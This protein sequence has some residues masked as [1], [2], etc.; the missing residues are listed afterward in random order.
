MVSK[1]KHDL[2]SILTLGSAL[3][4]KEALAIQNLLLRNDACD[5]TAPERL[6]A[7]VTQAV[8]LSRAG[9]IEEATTI[10]TMVMQIKKDVFG[11]THFVSLG[12]MADLAGSL[13]LHGKEALGFPADMQRDLLKTT[14]DVF[15]SDPG[16]QDKVINLLWY[17]SHAGS[18][19]EAIEK[20][21]QLIEDFQ[22]LSLENGDLHLKL[23]SHLAFILAHVGSTFQ[24]EN[25]LL[26]ALRLG[27]EISTATHATMALKPIQFVMALQLSGV[28]H[29]KKT[30][31]LCHSRGFEPKDYEGFEESINVHRSA[32]EAAIIHLS[33]THPVAIGARTRLAIV[34]SDV[35]IALNK[36]EYLSAASH[37]FKST[38]Q[39]DE[40]KNEVHAYYPDALNFTCGKKKTQLSI[41]Q[42]S[43]EKMRQCILVDVEGH[44]GD[45]AL[46]EHFI[47]LLLQVPGQYDFER[48]RLKNS[49]EK[50]CALRR[51]WS[52]KPDFH[53]DILR[54]TK[55]YGDLECRRGR[56]YEG[57]AL[58]RQLNWW[59]PQIFREEHQKQI[60]MRYRMD[61]AL[62]LCTQKEY[63]P[64]SLNI[65][66]EVLNA[67]L[68]DF[69]KKHTQSATF[70]C[71]YALLLWMNGKKAD[72]TRNYQ[73][74]LEIFVAL[75][76]PRHPKAVD[77][78]WNLTK[79]LLDVAHR[80]EAKK[81]VI[82]GV[83]LFWI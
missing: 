72:S 71:N 9:R 4:V 59:A 20:M 10:L 24:D 70:T 13:C 47:N 80:S 79:R 7:L 41:I 34:L 69:G 51:K 67:T 30:Q 31:Y 18:L 38:M 5:E 21:R 22:S 43:Y 35:G 73:E 46:Q 83:F 57:I 63:L 61:L 53:P 42:S 66:K 48:E 81:A 1:S 77:A 44:P 39:S 28:I 65:S 6:S 52:T 40:T 62:V 60:I 15:P 25:Y 27:T 33:P 55:L 19:C 78:G 75:L 37:L 11:D 26:E 64:K 82:A 56:T 29:S 68:S 14:I 16:I 32:L 49:I 36:D 12:C 54:A 45:L 50:H 8:A 3:Q 17:L 74:A 2:A 23:Q 76:G 58:L